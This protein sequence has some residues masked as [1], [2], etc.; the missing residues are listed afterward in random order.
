MSHK[1]TSKKESSEMIA[2]IAL[3]NLPITD[4]L[5]ENHSNLQDK[6]KSVGTLRVEGE[7]IIKISEANYSGKTFP[8]KLLNIIS[9]KR[10]S[11][12]IEWLPDGNAFIILDKK[13]FSK[14]I[15]PSCFKQTQ[16]TSFTRKLNRWNFNRVARGP[17]IGAYYHKCFRRDNPS[18]SV[19]MCCKSDQFKTTKDDSL[20][21]IRN[22][23]QEI[24]SSKSFNCHDLSS[25]DHLSVQRQKFLLQLYENENEKRVDF[26]LKSRKQQEFFDM[27]TFEHRQRLLLLE[28]TQ[29]RGSFTQ[30]RDQ[31]NNTFIHPQTQTRASFL[32]YPESQ[33]S[34]LRNSMARNASTLVPFS[35][36]YHDQNMIQATI[37]ALHHGQIMNHDNI[38]SL[39][40]LSSANKM[41][42]PQQQYSEIQ[43]NPFLREYLRKMQS[44]FN[45]PPSS[46]A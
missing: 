8:Q 29:R 19:H 13:R 2:A 46:A 11:E 25:M 37:Q 38:S 10:N 14:E 41:P 43:S 23:E 15:L 20:C 32:T 40:I 6:T 17:L 28:N 5:D 4:A 33:C 26:E 30:L 39:E 12:I 18:L 3:A 24:P 34:S 27:Q 22:K 45:L 21:L 35:D 7:N 1:Q 31:M 36:I 42:T 44:S 9:N 16:F